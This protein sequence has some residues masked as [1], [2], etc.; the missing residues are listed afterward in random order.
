MPDRPGAARSPVLLVLA[1]CGQRGPLML[2]SDLP[3]V[4]P[5]AAPAPAETDADNDDDDSE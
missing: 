3:E 5:V 2:P 1:D 4:E